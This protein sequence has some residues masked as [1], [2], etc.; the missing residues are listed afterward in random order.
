MEQDNIV[1]VGPHPLPPI[2]IPP[3]QRT[4][5]IWNS[6]NLGTLQIYD[7]HKELYRNIVPQPN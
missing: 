1:K 3:S 5:P 2:P 7:Y 4:G 6:R